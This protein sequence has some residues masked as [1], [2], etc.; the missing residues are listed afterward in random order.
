M[1]QPSQSGTPQQ[2]YE[3]RWLMLVILLLAGFMNLID[4][5][6]VN[7]ALPSLQRNL[8]ASASQIEWV[9]A[10]YI[11]AFA[12]GLLPFGRLGDRIGRK[13]MFLI[14]VAGFTLFSALCG[15]AP[16][17]N[18]LVA[19]RALQGFSGAMM[20]PQVLAI[21]TVT[22]PAKERG[23]AYSFFGLSAGLASVAGPLAGGLL[24]DADIAGLDWRPIFLVNIPVGILALVAAQ[25]VVPRL[26]G[27]RTIKN[28]AFGT[29]LAGASVFLIIFALIEGRGFG[30]PV[31][32]F[33]LVVLALVGF[34]FFYVY[35]HRR[36]AEDKAQLLPAHLLSNKNYMLGGL[37]V[38]LFFS[39]VAGFF[40]VLAL[41][42]QTGLGFT[43]LQSG[44]STI[45]F[46]VGVLLVSLV[47]NRLGN[48]YLRQRVAAGTSLL[49][50]AMVWL[51]FVIADVTSFAD[52]WTIAPALFLGGLGLG[53]TISSLFQSVLE[54]VPQRDAGSG[55]GALQSF[56]QMGAAFGVAIVGQIFFTMLE[57]NG[58][59]A[60][61]KAGYIDAMQ[62]AIYYEFLAFGSVA[63]LVFFLRSPAKQKIEGGAP[64]PAAAE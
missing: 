3:R 34:G 53:G 52:H 55:S 31:W 51:R 14:G 63:L 61:D 58:A 46:P 33:A 12:I 44:L 60:G 28:D 37:M 16:S 35:E 57:A 20:M 26:P 2:P 11:L 5:N 13:R 22:F 38:V 17:I 8:Q 49:V 4:V 47:N 50:L 64:A 10:A 54:H 27:D 25:I 9:V 62:T 32:I 43:P 41:L 23:A 48:R 1:S 39:G 45:P 36:N 6:I 56:Q 30:W 40:M 24:I 19:A 7:V 18:W 42:L 59:G 15:L 21:V 29:L